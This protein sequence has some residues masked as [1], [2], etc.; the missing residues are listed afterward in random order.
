MDLR[1]GKE[2][3]VQSLRIPDKYGWTAPFVY[4]IGLYALAQFLDF[5]ERINWL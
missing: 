3:G 4:M 2:T 5:L 1:P